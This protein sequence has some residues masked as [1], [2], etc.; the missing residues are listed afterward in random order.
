MINTVPQ[1]ICEKISQAPVN[2]LYA[3]FA[4]RYIQHPIM[5]EIFINEIHLQILNNRE[6]CVNCLTHAIVEIIEL[7]KTKK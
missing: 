7:F 3:A 4:K 2:P 6:N 1:E 5:A